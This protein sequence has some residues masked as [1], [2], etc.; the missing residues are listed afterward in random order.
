MNSIQFKLIMQQLRI[1]Y[2]I[3]F[4]SGNE[5]FN[6]FVC[7]SIDNV[8]DDEHWFQCSAIPHIQMSTLYCKPTFN[9]CQTSVWSR[10]IVC[11]LATLVS[12]AEQLSKP[13]MGVSNFRLFNPNTSFFIL[14]TLKL[15]YIDRMQMS[16]RSERRTQTQSEN[17]KE[18]FTRKSSTEIKLI[19]LQIKWMNA[20]QRTNGRTLHR[21]LHGVRICISFP[22]YFVHVVYDRGRELCAVPCHDTP[23]DKYSNWNI[24][25]SCSMLNKLLCVRRRM[26]NQRNDDSCLISIF[27]VFFIFF[28]FVLGVC[29][30]LFIIIIIVVTSHRWLIQMRT[31]TA[32]RQWHNGW[33]Q[34]SFVCVEIFIHNGTE[35]ISTRYLCIR[36]SLLT[37]QCT[38]NVQ[39]RHTPLYWAIEWIDMYTAIHNTTVKCWLPMLT[40]TWK[41]RQGMASALIDSWLSFFGEMHHS[42]HHWFAIGVEARDWVSERRCSR[43]FDYECKYFVSLVNI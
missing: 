28:F 10:R 36:D 2:R 16:I 27:S 17:E 34:I 11:W 15:D 30:A 7:D 41:W 43:S 40:E 20:M 8:G 38:V 12:H 14:F 31:V 19:C 21:C 4:R 42:K 1:I 26:S 22:L 9:R 23:D 13:A 32:H 5:D 24:K 3:E 37:S 18:K 29:V 6:Y 35:C 25:S 39:R 33:K